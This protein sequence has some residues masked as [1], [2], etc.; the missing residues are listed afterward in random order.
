MTALLLAAAVVVAPY[1]TTTAG[2]RVERITL[3]NARGMVVSIL[4]L[5]GIID[6]VRAADRRGRRKNVV[7]ALPDLAAYE[8]RANFGSLIGRYAGRIAGGGFPLDGKRVQLSTDPTAIV[9]HGGT[10]G[11]GARVW[12]AEPCTRPRCSAVTLRYT[13]PDGENGFPGALS[14]AVT[15]TLQPDDTLRLDYRATTTRTTV[16][17]LTHHAYWN[18]AGA[19]SGSA[20]G[21]YLRIPAFATLELDARRVPTGALRPVAGTAFDLRSPARIGDRVGS[22]DPQMRLARGFDHYFV[23][24][25]PAPTTL[26]ACAWDPGSGRMLHVRTSAPGVQFYTANSFDGTLLGAGGRTI[27]QGDG[28]AIETQAPP[29][30]PNHPQLAPTT[31]RTGETWRMTTR[32]HLTTAP[33]LAAF[34]HRC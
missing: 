18:L 21:Q 24:D 11:F 22:A 27:R 30:A 13:S 29:D 7:L 12:T 16:V 34:R 9:S 31:L 20:D 6:E 5:G 23:L 33:N 19:G 17:N 25:R 2:E 14:V 4:T 1:G 3:R 10:P 28:Y 15:Y 26:A 32:F 8:A